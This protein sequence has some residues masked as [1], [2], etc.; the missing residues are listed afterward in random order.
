MSVPPIKANPWFR[1]YS[2]FATDHKIQMLSEADQ[3]RFVMLLCLRCSNGDVT[4]HDSEVAFQLRISEA[5]WQ[6]TK[7]ELVTRNMIDS[8]NRVLNWEKRQFI[9]DSSAARVRRHRDKAKQACNV[10]VTAKKR[11]GNGIVTPPDTDTDTDT[12]TEK[13]NNPPTPLPG[14]P[15]PRKLVAEPLLGF[16]RFWDLY[17]KKVSRHDAE[18]AWKKLKITDINSPLIQRIWQA[19]ADYAARTPEVQYRKNAAT[20]LNGCCWNDEPL[21]NLPPVK[22]KRGFVC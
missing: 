18:K 4:L 14:E 22:E 19:A 15:H 3:R 10:T 1:L 16:E 21:V 11:R 9:S 5:E 13:N 17:Q 20:W 6:Q 12:D 2:E 8:S 7:R